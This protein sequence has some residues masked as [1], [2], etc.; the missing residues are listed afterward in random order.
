MNVLYNTS[1]ADPFVKVAQKLRDEHGYEPVYWIGFD[2]DHS[3]E[4]VPQLFPQCVYQTY[5]NAW[6]G[7]F[8]EDIQKEAVDC[9][10]DIDFL[11]KYAR[12]ELQAFTMMNRLDYDQYSFN[13]MER[14][15][16]FLKLL[17]S[18]M[19]VLDKYKIKLVVSS[20]NPHRVYDY[21]LYLLCRERNIPF[22]CFQYTLCP[23]RTFVS[24]NVYSIGDIFDNSYCKYLSKDDLSLDSLPVDIQN[25]YR[26]VLK[27]YKEAQPLSVKKNLDFDRKYKGVFSIAYQHI[28]KYPSRLLPLISK[29]YVISTMKKNRK[30]SL[31]DSRFNVWEA[32]FLPRKKM[33]L[34]KALHKLYSSLSTMPSKGEKYIFFPLHYQPEATT[35]PAGDVFVNQLLCIETLLR[36][37][38]EDVYIYVK[39]HPSQFQGHLIGQ[40]NRFKDF[41][42]DLIKNKRVRFMPLDLD[43]FAIMKDA[44][45]VATVTGTIGLEASLHK[46]P[47]IVFGMIW[48]EKMPGVL[49]ITDSL[50]AKGIMSFVD[51][52]IFDERK[53]LAYL[54][55]VADN[56]IMAYH[57]K[58]EKE[59]TNIGEET[60]VNNLVSEILKYVEKRN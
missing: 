28:R 48:Y 42:L 46:K 20:V 31:E 13:L 57:Y 30:Y 15:R 41:Y 11:N 7:I 4:I 47:V 51:N 12:Y 44:V 40:T 55:S 29:G 32:L 19:V 9:Y 33:S 27:S 60:C 25:R 45:A 18:W 58:G 35:S 52:Y 43:S 59:R 22:L 34:N 50:S 37:T 16:H 1:I 56:T 24:D 53:V 26:Q 49:R 17:K 2:Y 38:P 6:K 14:E 39:E 3:D 5:A 8:S 21:V 10:L 36:N 54:S 23:A